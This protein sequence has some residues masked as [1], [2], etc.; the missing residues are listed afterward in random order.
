M[1]CIEF[2]HLLL[3]LF[4]RSALMAPAALEGVDFAWPRGCNGA[5]A[6]ADGQ[7]KLAAA[8]SKSNGPN[9]VDGVGGGC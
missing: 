6:R 3:L 7:E 4:R 8:A 1:Y 2:L 5:N 9:M